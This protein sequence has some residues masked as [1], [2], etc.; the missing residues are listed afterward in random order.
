MISEEALGYGPAGGGCAARDVPPS[1]GT[2]ARVE[3][4]GAG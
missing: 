2:A 4:G 3:Y 1:G